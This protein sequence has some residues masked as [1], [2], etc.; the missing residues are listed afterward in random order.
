MAT[1]QRDD[2]W[3]CELDVHDVPDNLVALGNCESAP[4]ILV[5]GDSHA[6]AILPAIDALC[7][8]KHIDAVAATHSSTLPLRG[9]VQSTGNGLKQRA[10]PFN[11][12]VIEYVRTAQIDVVLLVACGWKRHF[13]DS[14]YL[15]ATLDTAR[16][17]QDEGAVVYL[18]NTVPTFSYDV[19]KFVALYHHSGRLAELK[20]GLDDYNAGKAF[21]PDALSELRQGGV[22]VLEPATVFFDAR[23]EFRPYDAQG[24]YYRDAGHLSTHGALAL[25][26]LFEPLFKSLDSGDSYSTPRIAAGLSGPRE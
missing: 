14:E 24:A 5:W 1:S 23:R 8:E 2:K 6:M 10:I 25:K 21:N 3:I 26:P 12:A 20:L 15:T 16:I 19:A 4:R 9:Y 11:D 22:R 18:M 17:L 7:R 13:K